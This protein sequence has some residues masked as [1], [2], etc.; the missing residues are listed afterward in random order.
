MTGIES[1]YPA[2][3]LDSQPEFFVRGRN[4]IWGQAAV[5]RLGERR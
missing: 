4:D 5:P 3:A 1:D 2:G